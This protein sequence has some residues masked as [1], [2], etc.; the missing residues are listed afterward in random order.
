MASSA[1]SSTAG[2]PLAGATAPRMKG[3][4]AL[5]LAAAGVGGLL[6][7]VAL[8]NRWV[9]DD[10]NFLTDHPLVRDLSNLPSIFVTH[11]WRTET[12][13]SLHRPITVAS[14]A[15][16]HAVAGPS[17][18]SYHLVNAALHALDV[19]LLFS[20]L[21]NRLRLDDAPAALASLLY[22]VHP[23]LSEAV[24]TLVGRADM[25]VALA[26]LGMLHLHLADYRLG[27]WGPRVL[28]PAALLLLL[29]GLGSKESAVAIPPLLLAADVARGRLR[30]K[31]PLHAATFGL[32]VVFWFG[33][34]LPIV[35]GVTAVPPRV[36]NPLYELSL[37]GRFLGAMGVLGRYVA[38]L[39]LP[40]KLS[41]DYSFEA[42]P[43]RPGLLDPYVL[44][45]LAAAAGS[46]AGF[47]WA[48][49]WRVLPLALGLAAMWL[50][51]FPVSNLI[52]PIGTI[53]AERC[54][55]VPALGLAVLA[56]LALSRARA[57]WPVAAIIAVGFT[58]RTALRERDW[59]DEVTFY[60][61]TAAG[62]RSCKAHYHCGLMWKL[63]GNPSAAEVEFR[64]ALAILPTYEPA[65]LD[66]AVLLQ[67]QGRAREAD[68]TYRRLIAS[69]PRG[70]GAF[71]GLGHILA[72]S[73]RAAEA[74][75]LFDR[76]LAVDPNAP[77]AWYGKGV[78]HFVLGSTAQA[79]AAFET[80]LRSNPGDPLS[81]LGLAK[82]FS[83]EGRAPDAVRL[84][85]EIVRGEPGFAPAWFALGE[86]YSA[87]GRRRD[88]V[89]A[90][91]RA[92]K[93]SP[94]DAAYRERLARERRR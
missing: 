41:A 21:R 1:S 23:A 9:R 73:G 60:S 3:A 50:P 92:L 16:Q 20:L 82:V 67:E 40:L 55:Y 93:L 29:L 79:R 88:A 89:G 37:P 6:Y 90:F 64:R 70:T 74:V 27:R 43:A 48:C 39:L 11:Y 25:F 15:L 24:L 84:L 91:E 33:V 57:L 28:L 35:A 51:L 49:A 66:L 69:G 76:A 46:I 17:P 83:R 77:G 59:R 61:R 68:E 8:P 45:G 19:W 62:S 52:L 31:L 54:L 10:Y 30:D 81:R 85:E 18:W 12:L 63:E 86:C 36:E 80:A 53:L 47:A 87:L 38:L 34:R 14:M 26:A 42:V 94:N 44:A 4:R 56:A 22:A 72:D 71:V 2:A 58:V 65:L 5:G 75:A 13:D 32:L 78:A 7:L